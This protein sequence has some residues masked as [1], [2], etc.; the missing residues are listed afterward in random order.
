MIFFLCSLPP[1]NGW[2]IVPL[3]SDP[4][5]PQALLECVWQYEREMYERNMS[6]VD[7]IQAADAARKKCRDKTFHGSSRASEPPPSSSQT[8]SAAAPFASLPP[9]VSASATQSLSIPLPSETP[10]TDARA[11]SEPAPAP[12]LEESSRPS[13]SPSPP[14]TAQQTSARLCLQCQTR[15]AEV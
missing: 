4:S 12:S 2:F 15:P 1:V 11:S 8:P 3:G 13:P 6:D 10:A 9:S 7:Y 5:T 14:P